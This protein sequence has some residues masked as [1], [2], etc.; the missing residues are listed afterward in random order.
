MRQTQLLFRLNHTVPM[1]QE[2][3]AVLGELFEGRIGEG[4][5]VAAPLQ[6]VCFDQ[7]SIGKNVIVNSNCLMMSRGGITIEDDAQIAANVSLLSNNHDLYER[8]VLTC[9]P[10][11]IKQG[12]WIGAGATILPGVTVGRYAVVGAASV[13]THDVPD[14][15]VAVG[16]P[17]RVT[18]MLDSSKFPDG[19]D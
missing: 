14:F 9:K 11:R 2:Y 5:F 18:K 4:S 3:A 19:T 8:M 1:S 10:I 15:A 13:V 17:A 6:G 12:A 16:N 7:V